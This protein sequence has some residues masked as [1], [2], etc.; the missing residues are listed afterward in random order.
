MK[1][2]LAFLLIL[3]LACPL[4]ALAEKRSSLPEALL[5][6]YKTAERT[7]GKNKDR[8]ISKDQIKTAQPAVDA[9]INGLADQFDAAMSAEMKGCANPKRNSRLDIHIVYSIS[10]ERCVSFLV[11]ARE[12]YKRVQQRSPFETRTYD[13]STGEQL[14]LTRFFAPDSSAWAVLSQRVYDQLKAFFPKEEAE[15]SAL[16]A[17]SDPEA[18][19]TAPFTLGPVTLSFHFEARALYPEHA[20]LLRVS[21]P[22]ADV[23]EMMTDF[24]RRE[25]DNSMYKMVALTFDDGPAYAPSAT[26]LNHLRRAGAKATFF[27]VG[28]RINEYKDI[29]LRE[30]DE[31]HSLQSHHYKH[32]DTTKSTPAR[33]QAYTQRFYDALTGLTGSAPSMLRPPY[34]LDKPFAQAKVNLPIIQWDVDTKD[35]TGK[36]AA[37]VLSVVRNET[38]DGSIILMHDIKEK[39][40][41]S[42]RAVL[43]WLK[44]RGYLCVSVEELALQ[45]GQELLPNHV[46]YSIQPDNAN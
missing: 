44:E 9:E 40:P 23:R 34:G 27:L 8:F 28:D 15:E 3:L 5:V 1:R 29:V 46:Y 45:Y 7:E 4:S 16:R 24:G 37:A 30:N 26:L 22:Y 35:W 18:L 10:G 32:T 12:S 42:A 25:T 2:L 36:S 41:E 17:L 21:I 31:G 33:I 43:E 20:S 38:K 11:L 14:A 19:K 39:T 6:E 13:M